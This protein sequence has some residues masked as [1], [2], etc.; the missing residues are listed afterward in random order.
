MDAS[1]PSVFSDDTM[2]AITRAPRNGGLS[3]VELDHLNTVYVPN[4]QA[5]I[6]KCAGVSSL[7]FL[8]HVKFLSNRKESASTAQAGV[9][10][11]STEAF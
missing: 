2:H 7:S 11:V 6:P 1:M 9:W 5:F 3:V 10:R 8:F 4:V